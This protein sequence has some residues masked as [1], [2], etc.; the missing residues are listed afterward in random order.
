MFSAFSKP[1]IPSFNGNS[2]L[3]LPTQKHNFKDKRGENSSALHDRS[4]EVFEITLNFST[5]NKDGLLF[6]SERPHN[7]FLGVGFENGFIK[8]VNNLLRNH[9][10]LIHSEQYFIDGAWH[11]LHAQLNK[12]FL[13]IIIDNNEPI[14]EN[15]FESSD[16]ISNGDRI[17]IGNFDIIKVLHNSNF[18]HIICI[19]RGF[20]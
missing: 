8:I 18:N 1:N 4:K 12:H 14:I 6:W 5:I 16:H 15:L 3:I 2:F 9:S 7:I 17:F 11:T 20:S 10:V 13:K 19:C